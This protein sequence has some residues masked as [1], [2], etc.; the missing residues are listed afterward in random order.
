MYKG[1]KYVKVNKRIKKN[2]SEV[3]ALAKLHITVHSLK[4][5]MLHLLLRQKLVV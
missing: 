4:M 2:V 3:Q 1:E 5:L